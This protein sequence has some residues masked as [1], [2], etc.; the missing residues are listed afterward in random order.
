[1]VNLLSVDGGGGVNI[2]ISVF[3][4]YRPGVRF[5]KTRKL[6]EPE[7]QKVGLSICCKGN[8]IKFRDMEHLRFKI[9][10]ELCHPKSFGTFEK[11]APG[12]V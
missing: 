1:M 7:K 10:R 12:P 4:D 3:S 8:K 9:Q 6:N 5:S 2:L 11:R